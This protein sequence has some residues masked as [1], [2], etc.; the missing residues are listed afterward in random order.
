M[1][2]GLPP[3][4]INK[5]TCTGSLSATLATND[6][7][8]DC[9]FSSLKTLR[10]LYNSLYQQKGQQRRS[11]AVEREEPF[12]ASTI[13]RKENWSKEEIGAVPV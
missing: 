13:P 10:G 5:C 12:A 7:K 1:V 2:D 8:I 9:M 11:I 3:P 4:Q 6:N